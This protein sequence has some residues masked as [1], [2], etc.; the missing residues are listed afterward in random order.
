VSTVQFS[1]VIPA[2][3]EATNIEATISR[4][5]T[6]L[7]GEQYSWELIVVDDGS[8]DDT[9]AVVR[10][11]AARDARIRIAQGSR[12]GKGAAVRRGMLDAH[13]AWRFMADADLSMPPDNIGRFFAALRESPTTDILIGSR[14]AAGAQRIGEPWRRHAAGRVFNYLAQALGVPGIRDTQCGFKM[15]SAE[16]ALALF[17][18]TAIDGFAFDVELL[19]LARRL[20]LSIREVGIEWHCRIDSRVSFWR[21]IA[22]FGDIIRVRW[23]AWRGKYERRGAPA[24]AAMGTS[25]A[26][27]GRTAKTS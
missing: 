22:A 18:Q 3:N 20:G 11:V 2:F 5:R 17:P 13:G 23:N 9:A 19:F 12:K 8:T 25:T 27:P 26:D 7:D 21:G 10:A 14:E 4:L 24:P 1:V 15:L 16:A 6:Y